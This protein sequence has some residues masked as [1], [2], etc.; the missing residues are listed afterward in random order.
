MHAMLAPSSAHMWANCPASLYLQG[1]KKAGLA[2]QEGRKAHELAHHMLTGIYWD[3]LE[4][5]LEMVEYVTEYVNF[6][7]SVPAAT[8]HYEQRVNI[9]DRCFGTADVVACSWN[10]LHVIDLKYGKNIPIDICNNEQLLLYAWGAYKTLWDGQEIASKTDDPHLVRI[11]IYQPRTK[12]QLI[13]SQTLKFSELVY[14]INQIKP[15]AK[16]ALNGSDKRNSG[17]WCIFCKQKFVCRERNV[18]CAW[19]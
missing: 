4:Y 3:I 15:K 17:D 9:F 16:L 14:F 5:P 12:D 13:K 18:K 7:T 19:G 2:A 1:D 6:V 11:S 8:K 10:K